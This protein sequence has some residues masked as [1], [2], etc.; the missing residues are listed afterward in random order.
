MVLE[1]V[2]TKGASRSGSAANDMIAESR[3]LSPP[4]TSCFRGA[5]GTSATAGFA[6]IR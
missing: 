4:A 1:P 5:L 6:D 3:Q 2:G